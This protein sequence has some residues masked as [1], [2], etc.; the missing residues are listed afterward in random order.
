MRLFGFFDLRG[1]F[2]QQHFGLLAP[3]IEASVLSELLLKPSDRFEPLARVLRVAAERPEA[4][5]QRLEI[6]RRAIV[7]VSFVNHG[8]E[9][10]SSSPF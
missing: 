5:L 10:T 9:V 1:E 6:R 7:R 8:T 4:P 2:W 3:R